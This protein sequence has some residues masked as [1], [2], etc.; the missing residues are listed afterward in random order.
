MKSNLVVRR[1]ILPELSLSLKGY[2][3]QAVLTF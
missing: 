1:L 2:E 3:A